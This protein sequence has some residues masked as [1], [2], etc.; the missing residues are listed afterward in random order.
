MHL[1]ASDSDPANFFRLLV[2]ALKTARPEL[3]VSS[4]LKTPGISLG[5]ESGPDRIVEQAGV[6]I[7]SVIAKAPVRLVLDG[8]DSLA[9]DADSLSL[10]HRIRDVIYPPSCLILVSRGLPPLELEDQRMRQELLVLDN[11]A[12]MFSNEEITQF[13][14]E[15]H[16]LCLAPAQATRIRQ[17]TDGWT[18]GLVLAWEALSQIPE[19]QRLPFI[20]SGLPR[21]HAR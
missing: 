4:F 20:D 19:D 3:D 13:F 12:L 8:L 15:L 10:V 1:D 16:D 17:I 7:Q 18:G 5:P 11:A 14:L 9:K 21:R 6:F 2:Q